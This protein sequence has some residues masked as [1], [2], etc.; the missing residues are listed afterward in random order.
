MNNSGNKIVSTEN[1][2]PLIKES[3][4]CGHKVKFT[5]SGYSMYPWI[6]HNRDQVL[7]A[8]A[9]ETGL[10]LGD[11][12][13]FQNKN[14]KYILHRIYKKEAEGYW[15][16]GDSCLYLDEMVHPTEIIG[17]V[18]K[19]YR[20]GKEIDCNSFLWHSIFSIWRLLLPARVYLLMLFFFVVRLK[21]AVKNNI[22]KL[23]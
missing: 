5:V 13:L 7:L 19:I 12:I 8:R 2:V 16:I 4:D 1:I 10:R 17:V 23:K 3:L 15:T 6:A 21:N 14:D 20:K 11:I 9:D 22:I 18:E